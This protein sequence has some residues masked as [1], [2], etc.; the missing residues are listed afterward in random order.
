M[1]APCF[2]LSKPRRV[3]D[4]NPRG[5]PELVWPRVAMVHPGDLPSAHCR[6]LTANTDA[7]ALDAYDNTLRAADA[8]LV[9]GNCVQSVA[10]LSDVE[11]S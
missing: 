9:Q 5:R 10:P 2:H 1:T 7:G 4:S 8:W 11:P 3:R 6:S